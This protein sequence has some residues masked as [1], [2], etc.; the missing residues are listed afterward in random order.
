VIVAVPDSPGA[1]FKLNVQFNELA[2]HPALSVADEA[3][4]SFALLLVTLIVSCVAPLR[5]SVTACGVVPAATLWLAPEAMRT[6]GGAG[7]VTVTVTL[8]EADRAAPSLTDNCRWAIP[9]WPTAGVIV[10]LQE[11]VETPQVVGAYQLP[12]VPANETSEALS[13][14]PERASLPVPVNV[15]AT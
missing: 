9:S 6:F 5:A 7:V 4:S 15:K 14:V 12:A 1:G 10:R 2:P 11:L 3:G 8:A 13:L